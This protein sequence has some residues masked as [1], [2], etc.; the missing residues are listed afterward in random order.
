MQS[1]HL[2]STLTGAYTTVQEDLLRIFF[3]SAAISFLRGAYTWSIALLTFQRHSRTQVGEVT[4]I[5]SISSLPQYALVITGGLVTGSALSAT[6]HSRE[7]HNKQKQTKKGKIALQAC[8]VL[9]PKAFSLSQ[10]VS[11]L[12]HFPRDLSVIAPRTT[13]SKVLAT[14]SYDTTSKG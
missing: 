3:L 9:L 13:S 4:S 7:W 5:S 12:L 1:K 11:S 10:S 2:P 8:D 14:H 6:K